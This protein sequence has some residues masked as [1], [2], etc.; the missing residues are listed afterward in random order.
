MADTRLQ[1]EAEGR[2]S[3][4]GSASAGVTD[5]FFDGSPN[6]AGRS[7][8]KRVSRAG[9]LFSATS[10]PLVVALGVLIFVIGSAVGV[11]V[12]QSGH[13]QATKLPGLS[14]EERVEPANASENSRAELGAAQ[15]LRGSVGR[16][17]EGEMAGGDD[18]P[19]VDV[20]PALGEDEPIATQ[21]VQ[22]DAA[23]QEVAA[24]LKVLENAGSNLGAEEPA[25]APGPEPAP[26]PEEEVKATPAPEE[27]KAKDTNATDATENQDKAEEI[28]RAHV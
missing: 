27:D 23:A 24:A 8:A 28:G 21:V 1:L 22:A 18:K 7:P 19:D 14:V 25:P 5:S 6:R 13:V 12:A 10:M 9:Q 3:A 20:F 4:Y 15:G 17:S 16:K 2:G 26:A 11:M